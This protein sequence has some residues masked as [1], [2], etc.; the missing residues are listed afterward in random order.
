MTL[1]AERARTVDKYESRLRAYYFELGEE[2]RVV[3]IGEKEV[4]E[5]AA[6][7]ARY[8]DLFTE[9]QLD[10]LRQAETGAEES[11]R[12]RVHRLRMS[13]QSALV[14]S[15]LASLQ[16]GLVNE[17]L[18]TRVEFGAESLPVRSAKARVGVL[19]SYRDREELGALAWDASARLNDRRL[20]LVR[21]TEELHASLSGVADPVLRSEEE[22]QISLRH[23]AE[24]VDDTIVTTATTYDEL[25]PRW[26][27]RILGRERDAQPSLYHASYSLRLSPLAHVYTT[28]RAAEVCTATLRDIGLDLADYSNIHTDLEDRPQKTA[29]PCVIVPD[30]PTVV[31]LITRSLG[32]LQDYAGLLHEAGH[33]FHFGGCDPD[34]PYTFRALARDNALSGPTRSFASRYSRARVAL[35][36]LRSAAPEA[37][38]H[39]EA[40]RFLHG[41]MVRRYWA[42]LQFELDFWGRF[43]VDGGT[44]DG[45]A[46]SLTDATGFAFRPDAFLSDLD[47]G[48][49]SAD[50]LRGWVRAAQMR[51]YLIQSVGPDWWCKKETGELLVEP[52]G[53][54]CARRTRTS[55]ASSVSTQA[56]HAHSSP[57][58]RQRQ[59]N[60]RHAPGMIRTCD[61]CLRRAALYPLSYGRGAAKSSWVAGDPEA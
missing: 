4:S 3:R 48:F 1:S 25:R 21:A 13:C 52:I 55:P 40:T 51:A 5:Q 32:G 36:L 23:L 6:I 53:T 16:D 15:A 9:E 58:S 42:K 49:Y 41:F 43:G 37:E 8:S 33:A 29:R 45:Y 57:S 56:T 14:F 34:L 19:S 7:A 59:V 35:P 20:E 2:A 44:P 61:L 39:S 18:R 10:A 38:A 50:Y 12:E 28:E 60:S 30:P 47:S 11:A 26:L 17:E 46:E 31:Y 54:G 27:D 24:T 22:K